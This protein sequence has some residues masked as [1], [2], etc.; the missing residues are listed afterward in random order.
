MPTEPDAVLVE[1]DGPV[2]VV[3]LN[4]PHVR[5]AVDRP[6]AELLDRALAD[7]EA[8]DS[9]SVA[10]LTGADGTFC[11]GADLGGIADGRGNTVAPLP[12]DEIVDSFGPMGPTRR[13]L[14]KPCL[15]AVEGHA[16]AGGL[17]LAVWCDLRIAARDA[18]FGV[19]C[20][21]WGVPLV[22]GGTIRLPRLIGHSR[23][24]DLIL[25]GREVGGEEAFS[26]GLAN[27][28]SESGEALADAVVLAH[29]LAA[30]PQRCLRS[31]RRSAHDQWGADL[32]TALARETELGLATI[33]S[34]E[35]REGASRFAAGAGRHG[36]PA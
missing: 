32:G 18:A 6:T 29:Q 16:V 1:R 24:M 20:R 19:F 33:A 9:L 25:T 10:V 14:S 28:L 22:D 26:I 2:M 3:T 11:A 36:A 27:R 15:A 23:A 34:G 13:L 35:T 30:L 12:A 31:D 8:D 5:N 4:R 17:E 21:R 7:F